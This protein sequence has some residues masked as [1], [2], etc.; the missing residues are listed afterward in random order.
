MV[1]GV[2]VYL[3]LAYALRVQ[4]LKVIQAKLSQRF[5]RK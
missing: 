5:L 3:G 2:L 4:E 1:A